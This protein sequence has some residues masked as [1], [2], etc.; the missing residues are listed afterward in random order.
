MALFDMKLFG[1]TERRDGTTGEIIWDFGWAAPDR[2]SIDQN[3]TVDKLNA[4][5]ASSVL[6]DRQDLIKEAESIV[7]KDHGGSWYKKIFGAAGVDDP[8]VGF[9]ISNERRTFLWDYVRPWNPDLIYVRQ[10]AGSCVGAGGGNLLI[11]RMGIDVFMF[12]DPELPKLPF[13]FAAYAKSREYLGMRGPGDGSSGTTFARALGDVGYQA[14]ELYKDK[15]PFSQTDNFSYTSAIELKAGDARSISTEI[16]AACKPHTAG[17]SKQISS[18]DELWEHIH[19]N[20]RPAT[21]ASNV[22]FRMNPGVGGSRFP[23]LLNSR[24]GTWNHQMTVLGCWDHPELGKRLF[25]I[26]NQWGRATHGRPLQGEPPGGFWVTEADLAVIIRQKETYVFDSLNGLPA[27]V[28]DW[29]TI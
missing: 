7:Q 17:L 2:R 19:L 15:Y 29:T 6:P 9:P 11:T 4:T 21:I 20:K 12:G 24:S 18:T 8:S 1:G 3:V 25:Y 13:W 5:L 23:V 10:N 16:Y 28:V 22:G 14:A 27:E 26:L